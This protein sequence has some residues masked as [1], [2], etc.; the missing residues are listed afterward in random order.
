VT[1]A[2]V[3]PAIRR[4]SAFQIRWAIRSLHGNQCRFRIPI[5]F[6][7]APTESN[8]SQ[9]PERSLPGEQV[10]GRCGYASVP[11]L[12]ADGAGPSMG[13]EQDHTWSRSVHASTG[14]QTA[15]KAIWRTLYD[16]VRSYGKTASAG[17]GPAGIYILEAMFAINPAGLSP[18][19]PRHRYVFRQFCH[20][21]SGDVSWGLTFFSNAG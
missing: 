13:H 15:D 20:G 1:I 12:S 21:R 11:R 19:G 8:G 17:N 10:G 18:G 7:S 14:Q 3:Y 5:S 2:A 16:A 9:I 4:R 6:L